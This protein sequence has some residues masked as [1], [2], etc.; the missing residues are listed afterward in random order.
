[1]EVT[2]VDHLL[3]PFFFLAVSMFKQLL[4]FDHLGKAIALLYP[5]Y[6][7]SVVQYIHVFFCSHAALF[8]DISQIK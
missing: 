1:M 4:C 5:T 6:S 2:I 8:S 7:C 3:K